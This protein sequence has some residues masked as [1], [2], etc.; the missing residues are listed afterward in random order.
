VHA[1]R[2]IIYSFMQIHPL[3]SVMNIQA[4]LH[5]HKDDFLSIHYMFLCNS[6]IRIIYCLKVKVKFDITNRS[7]LILP[8]DSSD[9]ISY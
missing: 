3:L 7:N 4:W 5:P 6:V 8:I 2:V 1:N 9:Q